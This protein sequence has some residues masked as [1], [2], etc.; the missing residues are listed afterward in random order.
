M[1]KLFIALFLSFQSRLVT[2]LKWTALG[3][4]A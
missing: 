4:Q 3:M 1:N 2:S